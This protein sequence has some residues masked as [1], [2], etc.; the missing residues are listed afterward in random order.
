MS[1]KAERWLAEQEI[2]LLERTYALDSPPEHEDEQ[3]VILM[4]ARKIR[5][6]KPGTHGSRPNGMIGE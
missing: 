6:R 5:R 3:E 4:E 1:K 2:A